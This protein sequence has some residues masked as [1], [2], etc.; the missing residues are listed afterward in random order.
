MMDEKEKARLAAEPTTG[1][2]K[3]DGPLP[4]TPK[5]VGPLNQDIRSAVRLGYTVLEAKLDLHDDERNV[6][7]VKGLNKLEPVKNK[8]EPQLAREEVKGS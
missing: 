7:R 5:T 6:A 1:N 8:L 2:T 4:E 3:D